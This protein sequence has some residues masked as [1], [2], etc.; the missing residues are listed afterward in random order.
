[1][2]QQDFQHLIDAFETNNFYALKAQYQRAANPICDS[3][4]YEYWTDAPSV[5]IG[6]SVNGRLTEAEH[7]HGLRN[8][9]LEL[10][11]LENMV[12]E[13]AQSDRWVK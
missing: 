6:L 12:D 10:T 5:T 11:G 8:A 4:E 9:P 7:Y 3:E 13:L 1:M 2:S